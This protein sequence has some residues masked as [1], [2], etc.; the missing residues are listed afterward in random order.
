[1]REAGTA[2][3]SPDGTQM[4][5]VRRAGTRVRLEYPI[6]RVLAE[7]TEIWYMRVSPKGD[8]VV[9]DDHAFGGSSGAMIKVADSRGKTKTIIERAG[10]TG[11]AW[12]PDGRE[13]WFSGGPRDALY[14]LTLDG[15]M[16]LL[17]Q[18][19]GRLYLTDVFHDGRALVRQ[20]NWRMGI[21]GRFEGEPN[22]R[23]LSW[24]ANSMLRDTSP[25]LRTLLFYDGGKGE[26][27]EGRGGFSGVYLRRVGEP[28]VHLGPGEPIALSPDEKWA[29]SAVDGNTQLVLLPTGAGEPRPLKREN[30]IY[31][32]WGRFLHGGKRIVFAAHEA[33]RGARCWVQSLEAGDRKPITPEGSS[34]SDVT[35]DERFVVMG[36]PG[37]ELLYPV[38]G[39]EP[40]AIPFLAQGELGAH[41]SE[42]RSLLQWSRDG[43]YL[44]LRTDTVKGVRPIQVTR[45][46]LSSG[47]REPWLE[48]SPQDRAGL[49]VRGIHL[50]EN[51]KSYVYAYDR[52]LS[53]LYLV[54]GLR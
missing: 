15:K 3:W 38:E 9:F 30:L 45:L 12:S 23:E 24:M 28:A 21:V 35:P 13:I 7:A 26:G 33:G 50:S 40:R 43:R 19:A 44:Y 53:D 46:D 1:M 2:D 20:D 49:T 27:W 31:E 39:G 4:A 25:D 54:E 36:T 22:D 18:S 29:L 42:W 47:R 34:C 41:D 51:G 52:R 11:L 10:V 16:R 37:K 6:G 8:R 5:V 17:Y 14:G 48:I 32:G